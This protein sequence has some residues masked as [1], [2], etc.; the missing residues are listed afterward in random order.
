MNTVVIEKRDLVH[1][2][3]QIKK[4]AE[5]NGPDDNGKKSK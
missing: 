2:I 3:E 1:N 5:I 4:H